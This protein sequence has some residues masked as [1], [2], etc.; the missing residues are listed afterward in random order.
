MH[1]IPCNPH[2]SGDETCQLML[3]HDLNVTNANPCPP[4]SNYNFLVRVANCV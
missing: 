1:C 3:M 4:P 2:I